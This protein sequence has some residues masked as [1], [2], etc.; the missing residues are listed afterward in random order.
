MKRWSSLVIDVDYRPADPHANWYCERTEFA[1]EDLE[2]GLSLPYNDPGG[3][4]SRIT[5]T[6]VEEKSVSFQYGE[7]FFQLEDG[8]SNAYLDQSGRDYTDFML[9]AWLRFDEDSDD[10]EAPEEDEPDEDDGRWDA[11]V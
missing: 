10:G 4:F 9:N 3:L 8:A 7:K 11:Y 5:I 2:A 6:G 1:H